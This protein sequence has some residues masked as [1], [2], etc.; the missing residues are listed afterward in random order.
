L[1]PVTQDVLAADGRVIGTRAQATRRRLLDATGKLLGDQGVLEL[2]VVDITREVGT[3]PA[4]FYQYFADV[5]AAI[6]ALADEAAEDEHPLLV[7]LSGWDADDGLD[8]ARAFVDEYLDYW[9]DHHPV[10]RMRNLKAE[11]GD[12]A[13]R[14]ARSRA[15]LL[16]IESMVD[17]VRAGQRSGRLPDSLEPF[18]TA[19]AMLAMIERL[20]AYQSELGRRG[21]NRHQLRETIATVLHRTLVGTVG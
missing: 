11:E 1:A 15:N 21:T 5:D 12:P 7:H 3:S 19:A 4:T 14:Q 18:A 16:V 10:L 2:K 20:L 17:M 8:R 9:R 13:F 6:L